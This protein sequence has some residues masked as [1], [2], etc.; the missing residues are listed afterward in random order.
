M[1]A[2]IS[3]L[4]FALRMLAKAPLVTAVA[5]LSLGLGIG[6]N[7]T[8]YAWLR[9]AVLRP[10]PG[11]SAP[12][13]LVALA[14]TT[15]EKQPVDV[16]YPDYRDFAEGQQLAEYAASRVVTVSLRTDGLPTRSWAEGVTGNFFRVGGVKPALGRLL[17][18]GDEIEGQPLI[19]VL[20]HGFWTRRMGADASVIGHSLRI[21]GLDCLIVGVTSKDFQGAPEGG[22]AMDVFVPLRPF[23]K[24]MSWSTEQR[25]TRNLKIFGR[26]STGAGLAQAK[27]AAQAIAQDLGTKYPDTNRG[28]GADVMDLSHAPWGAQGAL[29]PVLSILLGAVALILLLACANVASLLLTRAVSRQQELAIRSAL[30][31][32]PGRLMRQLLTESLV[33][34]LAGGALGLLV[35]VWTTG[36]LVQLMP[37]TDKP[38]ALHAGLDFS[39]LIFTLGVSIAT[40][41]LLGLLPMLFSRSDRTADC[42]KEGGARATAGPAARRWLGTMVVG[43]MALATMLLIGA[44]LMIKSLGQASQ[45]KLGFDPK[46]ILLAGMELDPNT[47]AGEREQI[48]AKTVLEKVRAIPGVESAAFSNFVPLGLDGG[49][50]EDLAFQG[51]TPAPAESMKLW[52]NVI[53]PG[54]FETLHMNLLEGRGFAETDTSKSEPVIVL[55]EAAAKRYFPHGALGKRVKN[56]G[57][58]R[59][60]VGIVATSKVHRL[61][62]N[63]EPFVYFPVSQWCRTGLA[64]HVRSTEN[65]AGLV[66]SIRGAVASVDPDLPLVIMPM[67]SYL[68][69]ATMLLRLAASL[70]GFLGILALGLASLGIFAVMSFSVAQRQQEMGVR[71]ALGAQPMQVLSLVLKHGMSLAIWGALIGLLL[72]A[73]MS[74]ALAPL[75][76]QVSPTDPA[77]LTLVPLLLLS[78]AFAACA[79]PA[80]RAARMDPLSALRQS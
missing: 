40:G 69:A 63:P 27:S 42:L 41:L 3:D 52:N 51:Y 59:T 54:Y 55:N 20:G 15:Q 78:V 61:S 67:E 39:V 80:L 21:N 43:E 57:D 16:S 9:G 18:P 36:L 38:L 30:G 56:G 7:A 28:M 65:S 10:V 45:V 48:F 47:Y 60:V 17:E 53:T 75:L 35:S 49:S 77:L 22:L 2:L 26:L 6:A 1:T 70:L 25:T 64:L 37:P 68:E 11:V 32:N 4:K 13:R 46:N 19:A 5:L 66:S 72:M 74:R 23:W 73:G 33:L 76:L 71:L 58:W 79:V 24:A 29:R 34:G 31:A 14:T 50:W 62:E 12:D 8:V 44:G